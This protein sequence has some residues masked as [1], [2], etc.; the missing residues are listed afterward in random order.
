MMI[1]IVDG[2]GGKMGAAL[3]EKLKAALPEAELIAI[4]TNS[5]ATAAMM[6]AGATAGATGENPVVVNARRAD[7][8][9]GPIGVLG[10]NSMLGE[11]TPAM[12]LA[13]ADSPAQKVLI[14][15]NRCSFQVAGVREAPLAEYIRDAVERILRVTVS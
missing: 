9:T 12:A 5:A 4:G 11:V 8:I 6:K 1:L 10:A 7:V 15:V 2:Q 14:P 13:I 3:V